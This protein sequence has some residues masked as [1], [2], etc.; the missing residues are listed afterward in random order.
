MLKVGITGGIGSGKSTVCNV[1]KNLGVPVFTSD[2]VAKKLLNS[3][4]YLKNEIKKTFD[5]DMY[6]S[7][8]RIDRE[9]M[10]KLVFNNPDDL[11][12]LNELVHPRVK[13]EFDNWCKKNEKKPYVVK[14]A[15]ILFETGQHKE[16]DKMVTVFC[17]REERI[18]RLISRDTNATQESIEKRMIHQFS[19]AER[20]ALADYI[21]LNDGKEDLLPQVM[22]LHELL[23]NQYT[24]IKA[25]F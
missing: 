16:L 5:S 10:A 22:E 19:D 11:K 6:T 15:A 21:I 4:D 25:L 23:L 14:E 20:N 17:P 24:K 1:L 7:T 12:R 2:D 9:R 18:R 3:D 13:A 8:D